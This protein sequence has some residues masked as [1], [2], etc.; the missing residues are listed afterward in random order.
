ARYLMAA[1]PAFLLLVG[2]GVVTL[3]DV[4][5]RALARALPAHAKLAAATCTALLALAFV[6]PA[7]RAYQDFRRLPLRCSEFFLEPRIL[8]LA[9]GFC[10]R[11]IVL[12]S[13]VPENRY[14]L[15]AAAPVRTGVAVA[16]P[17]D[18]GK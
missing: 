10:R 15:R 3:F 8:D 4:A 18:Q 16:G 2:Y 1:H 13:L 6:V 17:G 5:R 7:A 9:G 14:P 12:N 11:Q